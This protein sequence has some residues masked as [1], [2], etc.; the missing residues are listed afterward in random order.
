[1]RFP[2]PMTRQAKREAARVRCRTP[3]GCVLVRDDQ[4]LVA[5]GPQ[6]LQAPAHRPLIL[7]L[8]GV[9][10]CTQLSE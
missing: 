9:V 5:L 2:G 1:M 10:Y 8:S 6:R 7:R 4:C 3:G